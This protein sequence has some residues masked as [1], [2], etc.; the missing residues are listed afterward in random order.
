MSSEDSVREKA[1]EAAKALKDLTLALTRGTERTVR[2]VPTLAPRLDKTVD[3]FAKAFDSTIKQVRKKT[4]REQVK[5]LEA[6][7][8]L[9]H[10][11][12]DYVD[13]RLK[14]LTSGKDAKEHPPQTAGVRVQAARFLMQLPFVGE[15]RSIQQ[16]S[17]SLSSAL[18]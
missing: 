5:L 12:L 18:W 9:L 3:D 2:R 10:R 14:D 13:L 7:R 4:E 6:Y 8:N 16:L 11:Q 1:R 15:E 17:F